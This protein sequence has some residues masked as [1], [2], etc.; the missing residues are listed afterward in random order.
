VQ[1]KTLARFHEVG[2][3]KCN[4]DMF[5]DLTIYNIPASLLREFAQKIVSPCYPGGVSEAVKDLMR[6]AILNHDMNQKDPAVVR[7][8]DRGRSLHQL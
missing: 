7:S 8:I 3:K 5:V 4:D 2:D 1:Q 6:R